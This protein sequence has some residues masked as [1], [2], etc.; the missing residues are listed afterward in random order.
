MYGKA[1]QCDKARL[2]F[3]RSINQTKYVLKCIKYGKHYSATK[4]DA[5]ELEYSEMH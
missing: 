2:D 3:K 1:L 4:R 5:N